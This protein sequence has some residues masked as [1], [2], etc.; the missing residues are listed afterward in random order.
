MCVQ[1]LLLD[2]MRLARRPNSESAYHI[3]YQLLAGVDSTVRCIVICDEYIFMTFLS[4]VSVIN[5]YC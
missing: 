3:F 1:I 4:V 2:V 5:V